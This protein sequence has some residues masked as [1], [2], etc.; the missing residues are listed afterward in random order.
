MQFIKDHLLAWL[1]VNQW[2]QLIEIELSISTDKFLVFRH[3]QIINL[4]NSQSICLLGYL[5]TVLHASEVLSN[6]EYWPSSP[7][8]G[9]QTSYSGAPMLLTSH[10]SCLCLNFFAENMVSREIGCRQA[11]VAI[12]NG[13]L[14]RHMESLGHIYWNSPATKI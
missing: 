4:R 11:M 1:L 2:N 9:P 12:I 5:G 13:N 3:S 7:G 14:C 6:M 10:F 8:S